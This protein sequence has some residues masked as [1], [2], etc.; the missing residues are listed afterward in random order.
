MQIAIIPAR[1]GS[2]R[3]PKKSIRPFLGKPLLAYT[4]EAARD[5]GF[6]DNIIVS[7]D[8]EEFAEVAKKYGAEV[9]FM[10]PAELADDFTAT[11]PVIEHALEWVKSNMGDVERYCQFYANPFV[12]VENIKGGY[13]LMREKRANCVLGVTE[14]AYPILRAFQKNEQGGVEYAFPEY[15]QSRSQ[16]L[17]TFFHDAAQFYW[18]E[19]TD[20]PADR[21]SPLSL[22]YFLPRYMAVDIDTS[23]DWIIAEKL[24]Q[25]F[26][27]NGE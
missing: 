1:G 23:G 21:K 6:F 17:P 4:I 2:K 10:R 9:P 22:P 13:E 18:H 7:T 3:I 14:F 19:L 16:D 8:S 27:V 12:T 25:A 26:C 24:Y 11:A 5:S 20:I 15:S